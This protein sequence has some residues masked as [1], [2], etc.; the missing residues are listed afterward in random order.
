MGYEY[1]TDGAYNVRSVLYTPKQVMK[2]FLSENRWVINNPL[3]FPP[4][5]RENQP[6][7]HLLFSVPDLEKES[8]ILPQLRV[9]DSANGS[10]SV[11]ARWF[12]RTYLIWFR[13]LSGTLRIPEIW[14]IV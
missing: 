4:R 5:R 11:S 10:K 1:R 3:T 14:S 9:P 8:K 13:L 2:L 7:F 6:S 12:S